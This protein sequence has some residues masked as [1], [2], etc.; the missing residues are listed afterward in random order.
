MGRRGWS[1]PASG[2]VPDCFSGEYAEYGNLY[3]RLYVLGNSGNC[4]CSWELGAMRPG[5]PEGLA[6]FKNTQV[7]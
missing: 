4:R 5:V 1:V 7:Y 2:A 3:T 6:H